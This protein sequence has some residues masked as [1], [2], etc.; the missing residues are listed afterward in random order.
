MHISKGFILAKRYFPLL[1]IPIVLDILNLGEVLKSVRDFSFKFAVP[2]A[3][4]SISQILPAP[5]NE[6]VGLSAYLPFGDLKGVFLLLFIVL[7]FLSPFLKGGFL[8]CILSGIKE[9]EVNINTFIQ[10]GRKFYVRFLMEFFVTALVVLAIVPI[11]YIFG[12]LII[13]GLIAILVL[14]FFLLFWDYA[15]VADNGRLFDSAQASIDLVSANKGEVFS[16]I[17]PIL[18]ASAAFSFI[19]NAMVKASPMLAIVAIVIYAFLGTIVVFAMMSYYM[20]I[21]KETVAVEDIDSI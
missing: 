13:F 5:I 15:M 1:L 19:A 8:A 14:F 2:S 17:L 21:S 3:V 7:M 12:P 16:F 11:A 18:I 4:P 6:A 9:E 10:N 20:D